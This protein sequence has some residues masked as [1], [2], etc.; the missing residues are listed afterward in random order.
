[1]SIDVRHWA[2]FLLD[3]AD[4]CLAVQPI[5]G[6]EDLSLEDAYEIQNALLALRLERGEKLVGAKVGLTSAAKQ[7][8]MGVS[9]PVYGWLT[10]AMPLPLE[11]PVPL[12]ELIHPRA[13]P[14]IVFYLGEDLHGPGV[15]AQDVLDATAW[16]GGGIEVIDSRYEAF[17]F[18]L[19][20]VIADNTSAARF[21]LGANRIRPDAVDLALLGVL[22]EADG[23]LLD[24]ATGAALVG[25]PAAS[26]ALLANHLGRRHHKLQKGWVVLAGGMT[27]ATPLKPGTCVEA[28]YA[29]LGRVGLRATQEESP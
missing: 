9:E 27:G 18:K 8:Q 13:E 28:T 1:M 16:V 3:A 20:D 7:Q 5:T 29:H 23:A 11:A 4:Q 2:Q 10:D 26:V 21:A 12:A 17:N 24:T 22:F 6:K 19:P 25:H 15:T 14:E